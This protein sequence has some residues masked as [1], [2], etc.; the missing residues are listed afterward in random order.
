MLEDSLNKYS[1]LVYL[2]PMRFEIRAME[3]GV[4]AVAIRNNGERSD[5]CHLSGAESNCFRLLF[6]ISL[7]P[8][9]PERMRTNFLI[10]DEPDGAC[11]E[12]V[13]EHLIREF[14]PKLRA[15]VPHVFW[16]T[17]KSIDSFENCTVLKVIK[18]DGCFLM[19]G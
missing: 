14:L 8:L 18:E 17:P 3:T 5:I 16:I 13:R 19:G 4:S 6:A 12:P 2:E 9:L 1:N 7:L 15:I 10:L 11:S